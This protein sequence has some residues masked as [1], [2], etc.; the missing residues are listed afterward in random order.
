ML[1]RPDTF[2]KLDLKEYSPIY[3]R[4]LGV[5]VVH[6]NSD[7]WKRYRRVCNPAFK[8]IPI[9]FFVETGLKLMNVLERI[10]NKPIEVMDLMQRFTLDALGKTAFGF[11]FNNLEDPDNPYVTTYNDVY[12]GLIHNTF[13][14]I[15]PLERIPFWLN[16]AYKKIDKLDNLFDEIIKNKHKLIAAGKSNG[17]LLELMIKA[18]E[19]PNN[20][21]LTD[22][23][24]RYNLAIFMFAGHETTADALSTLLYL[25]AVHKDIQQ[26]AREEVMEIL[27][28]SLTPSAEQ[29]KSLKY[30]N[31]LIYENLRMYPSVPI[32]SIRK[33]SEDLKCKNNIIPAGTSIG[34]YP[35]GIHHSPTLWENPEKF[36]PERFEN[37][38]L[39]NLEFYGFGG[40]S[41]MCLGNNFSLIEQRILLCLLLRK[42]EL[43]LDPNSI[44][45]DGLK[46][47]RM[48]EPF[49][50]KLVFKRRND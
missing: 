31:M 43:S 10:D 42:Y 28:D 14:N 20:A 18:C 44:H 3:S 9:H 11:D 46:I 38:N 8:T 25:L 35:Y 22:V 5:N 47:K 26:K 39:E 7:I 48:T 15:F 45:K 50:I 2:P 30:I 32:L 27:G 49:P 12:Q 23:E 19:D 33:L 36:I 24:L 16:R 41:R 34:I 29:L 21:N 17:D 6:S 40:G 4:H 13:A 37:K 1:L